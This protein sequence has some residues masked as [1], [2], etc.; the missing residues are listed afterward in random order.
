ME[1]TRFVLVAI[2]LAFSFAMGVSCLI[3]SVNLVRKLR[4]EDHTTSPYLHRHRLSSHD[5]GGN[6]SGND[7]GSGGYFTGPGVVRGAKAEDGERYSE[8][9]DSVSGSGAR[10]SSRRRSSARGSTDA[11]AA[12]AAATEFARR[13]GIGSLLSRKAGSRLDRFYYGGRGVDDDGDSYGGSESDDGDYMETAVAMT[14]A[15]AGGGVA[16]G[17]RVDDAGT[18]F[19]AESRGSSKM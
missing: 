8:Q 19:V 12:A 3:F 16:N 15:A 9:R 13:R 6:D 2:E 7:S 14:T 1:I 5:S 11:A 4:E 10:S 17:G 18:R